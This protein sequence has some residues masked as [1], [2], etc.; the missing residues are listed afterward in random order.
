MEFL[1]RLRRNILSL[2]VCGTLVFLGMAPAAPAQTSAGTG[3]IVGTVFDPA[4]AAVPGAQVTATNKATAVK[5]EV[6]SSAEGQY[7]IILLPPGEYTVA[8]VQKGFKTFKTDVVVAV[9]ATLTLN[10]NLVLG[11][12]SEVVEVVADVTIA[13]TVSQP[14]SLINLRS[15]SDLPIVGRRFQDFAQL[16]PTVQID[17]Q[18][19]Q[20]SF[21]GQ[22]GINSNVTIDG[23]DYYQ[24]FFGGMRGGER[25]NSYFT[26]P[27]SA[28]EEFQAIP[29]GYSAE[30]GR[31][32]GGVLNAV[33][34]SGTNEYH[35]TTFFYLRH[36]NMAARDAF[37]REA[38]TTLKQWGGGIGGPV[39]KDKA[40]FYFGYEQ[41][42]N[43]NP[44]V[45]VF[46][47]LTSVV[48]GASNA[49][50]YD[51]FKGLEEPFVQT[52]DGIA[53]LGRWDHQFNA[54]HRLTVRYNYS[55][56]KAQNAVATGEQISPQTSNSLSNNG[57]EGDRV[58]TLAGTWTG[59]FSPRHINEFRMQYSREDRP[60]SANST[61]AGTSSAIGNT[62][63]R[64]FLPTTEYDYRIQLSDN[65]NWNVGTHAVKFGAD[66]NHLYASQ[67]FKF[68][69]FGIYSVSGSNINTILSIMSGTT[70]AGRFDS[71]S[72]SYNV[73][74]GNGLADMAQKELAFY[75]QDSWRLTPRFT[76]NLG[77]R[78][79][80]YFNPQ[81]DTSNTTLTNLVANTTFPIG[82]VNPG[83]IPNN[84]NQW[85]PR[86]GFA[87]DPWGNTKTVV[88]GSAGY[89][90]AANP[91][92]LFAT[93]INN[94]RS[95]PGD[96]SLA[97]PFAVPTANPCKTLYCQ[98][99]L[100]GINLSTTSLTNLPTVNSTQ[101]VAIA[102][103]LGL[104]PSPFTGANVLTWAD[105]YQSPR[106][107]QWNIGLQHEI[108]RGW[109]VAVD[110]TFINT[111]HL[112]RNRDFNLPRPN[113]ATGDLSLRECFGLR[114][115]TPAQSRPISSLGSVTV[116]EST[117]RSLYRAMSVSSTYRRSRYQF[118]AYYTLGWSYSS[119]DNERSA[120]GFNY[121]NSFNLI[122]E[123]SF[124]ELDIRHQLLFNTVVDLPWG[125]NVSSLG[126]FRTGRPL[127]ASSGLSDPN[128]DRGGPD[129]P[130]SAPGVPFKR[131]AFRN[132]ADYN[133]DLR[134]GKRF[135]LPKEGLSLDL[136]ADFF[137]IFN[138]DN[139]RF[140]GSGNVYGAGITTSGTAA[141]IDARFMR[142]INPASCI[143]TDP[144]NG[145]NNCY[146]TT[147]TTPGLP[148][149]MQV[150]VRFN[151]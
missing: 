128:G 115:C 66:F 24:P 20:I 150:G 4:G 6:Q 72:A 151:F 93:A 145:N 50:A 11:E 91:L 62:G 70:G 96:V 41:Q 32:T 84:L 146:D 30:F 33:T 76:V 94:F 17:Q 44:R 129:R 14:E 26:L 132:R 127:D 79:E 148:F 2:L 105:N 136:T 140:S 23:A 116:R 74:I 141:A 57:T 39:S 118:Q 139:I 92:L 51:F 113:A 59:I 22:R 63:T 28:V 82:Q 36:K 80:G 7:R 40:H 137:N 85:M 31:S 18:R 109:S 21:A 16:T 130:F 60:R 64:S 42:K 3:Q 78:W 147:T 125:F 47:Q 61:I 97:M 88:R 149:Q 77:L 12:V 73:A 107:L 111:V 55:K 67:F 58:N 95:T 65:F 48:R 53:F 138:F 110:Y 1:T 104:T 13:T 86:V 135:P 134:V 81:P 45:I 123:Y 119:D 122:P 102:A 121:E 103:A 108:A 27:Q 114:N 126:K 68:N 10:A 56:N 144:K 142:L 143:T 52:N 9:G 71:S 87:W 75:V 15:I 69:Q 90:Y 19:G 83:F 100:I 89:F 34:K 5:Q 112:E 98:F 101:A 117:A 131:N 29:Y 43:D 8:V 37:N 54:N 25:S 106:S 124:A 133:L 49:N 120:G 99:N 35:G 46:T 38:I